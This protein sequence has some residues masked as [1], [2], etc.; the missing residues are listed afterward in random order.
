MGAPMLEE[1]VRVR[2]SHGAAPA[3]YGRGLQNPTTDINHSAPV[4]SPHIAASGQACGRGRCGVVGRFLHV[5][6]VYFFA[7]F[8]TGNYRKQS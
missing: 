5:S 4:V 8:A 6:S 2:F 1:V 7:C 3:S